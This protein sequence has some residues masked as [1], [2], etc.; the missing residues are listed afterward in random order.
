MNPGQ[1]Q[2]S[3]QGK[4]LGINHP[5]ANYK[6]LLCLA[7]QLNGMVNGACHFAS[8][9]LFVLHIRDHDVPAIGQGPVGQGEKSIS[10][11]D[12]GMSR[13]QFLKTFQIVGQVPEQ[14]VVLADG[15]VAGYGNNDGKIGKNSVL[16]VRRIWP[17]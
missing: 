12:Q 10:S 14:A 8:F 15:V 13:G 5:S 11:H 7:G 17:L 9:K 1:V 3:C 16:H 2:L 6:T 4:E